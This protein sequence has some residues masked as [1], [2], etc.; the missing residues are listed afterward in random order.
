MKSI[1]SFNNRYGTGM[2]LLTN[3][4]LPRYGTGPLLVHY[5]TC[6]ATFAARILLKTKPPYV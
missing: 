5:K 6:S 2:V 4:L 3:Y 1:A